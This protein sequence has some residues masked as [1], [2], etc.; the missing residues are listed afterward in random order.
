MESM[1]K[2]K[3]EKEA[4]EDLKKVREEF[5]TIVESIELQNDKRFMDSYCKAKKQI[6]QGEFDDWEKL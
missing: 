3:V 2:I 6:E 4:I 1:T 5:D